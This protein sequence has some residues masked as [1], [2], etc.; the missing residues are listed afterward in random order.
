MFPTMG[1]PCFRCYWYK[2]SSWVAFCVFVC[3]YCGSRET[4]DP[5]PTKDPST[6]ERGPFPQPPAGR[7]NPMEVPG[8]PTLKKQTKFILLNQDVWVCVPHVYKHISAQAEAVCHISR[9]HSF[10]FIE[11]TSG[12][13]NDS[14]LENSTRKH[15]NFHPSCCAN[16]HCVANFHALVL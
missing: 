5:A 7:G 9:F 2:W 10:T 12:C 3:V 13:V 15:R 14:V 11:G 16:A 8:L 4:Q 1:M 6:P